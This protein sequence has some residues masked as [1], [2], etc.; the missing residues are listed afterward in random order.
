[1]IRQSTME[2]NAEVKHPFYTNTQKSVHSYL[3]QRYLHDDT[4]IQE[5][6]N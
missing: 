5:E 6:G 3:S 2:H 1:M 4:W